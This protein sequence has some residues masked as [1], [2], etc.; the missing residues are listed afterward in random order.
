MSLL[1]EV[2]KDLDARQA[3]G[4]ASQTLP[5]AVRP[6]P[7]RRRARW[8]WGIVLLFAAVALALAAFM[9][10]R[11][12]PQAAPPAVA[13]AVLA[14]PAPPPQP[15]APGL[16]PSAAPASVAPPEAAMPSSDATESGVVLRRTDELPLQA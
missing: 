8:P 5:S 15:A 3:A 13:G 7:A 2:L 10:L 12:T 9:V 11:A 1:N 6:L 14:S 4:G 16:A